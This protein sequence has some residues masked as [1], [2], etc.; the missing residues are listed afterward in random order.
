M[1]L[2]AFTL[3]CEFGVDVEQLR[4][5]D[6]LESIASRFFCAAEASELWITK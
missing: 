3:D 5:V 2:Y 6:Y 1:G 4:E